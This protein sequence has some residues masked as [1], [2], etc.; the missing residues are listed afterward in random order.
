MTP[1]QQ[2]EGGL[3]VLEDKTLNEIGVSNPTVLR[4]GDDAAQVPQRIGPV[5]AHGT[6]PVAGPST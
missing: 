3:V 5:G 4:V 6:S 1:H 2:L